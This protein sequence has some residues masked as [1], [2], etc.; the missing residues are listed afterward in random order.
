MLLRRIIE[1]VKAQNWTAIVIDFIIVVMGVFV[2]LQVSNWNE[3]R[4]YEE[5]ERVLL[6]ELRGEVAQNSADAKAKGEAFLVG[7]AAGRRVLDAIDRGGSNCGDDCWPIIVDL[8]HASQWQQINFSWSTYDELRREG[9]PS[10]RRIIELVEKFKSYN[11][12]SEQALSVQPEYRSLVRRLI[13]IKLQDEYWKGCYSL[14]DAIEVYFYP[15]AQPDNL[16]IDPAQ[17]NQIL[18]HAEIALTLREWTSLARVIGE[19]LSDPPQVIGAEILKRLD[20]DD[21]S[22]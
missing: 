3:A 18:T 20:E 4:A 10:D 6:R 8:M 17:I 9:L 13:P 14:D 15:C 11:H 19:T 16:V 1:H 7:A 2:G 22:S 5:H 12:Q 21:T